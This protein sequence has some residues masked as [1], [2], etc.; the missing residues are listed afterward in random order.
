MSSRALEDLQRRLRDVEELMSAREKVVGTS[1]GRKWTG[2]AIV[3]AGVVM[4]CAAAEAFVKDLFDEA[5]GLIFNMQDEEFKE[6]R[7]HTNKR[8]ANIQPFYIDML[9]FNLGLPFVLKDIKWQ[10]CSNT[11]LCNKLK[12]LVDARNKI[13]HGRSVKVQLASLKSWQTMISR[14]SPRLENKVA[15]H[16]EEITGKRPSWG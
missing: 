16:I 8:F 9:Y 15:E 14:L 5:A 13:A 10:N 12:K 11:E 3:R 4:L 6:F 7:R 1:R 2:G